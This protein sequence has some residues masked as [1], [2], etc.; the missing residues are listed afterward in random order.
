MELNEKQFTVG[1]NCG[2]LLAKYEPQTLT[3]ILRSV[4][5]INSYIIGLSSGKQEYEL[6]QKNEQLKELHQIRQKN[7]D[8]ADREL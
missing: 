5:P 7:S 3:Y 4:Q 2:Y 8:R 6:D 1:F